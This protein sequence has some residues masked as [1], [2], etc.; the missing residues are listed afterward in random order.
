MRCAEEDSGECLPTDILSMLTRCHRFYPLLPPA[1]DSFEL[2][3]LAFAMSD[4]DFLI[5]VAIFRPHLDN[6]IRG[7]LLTGWARDNQNV[8]YAP[9]YVE[10]PTRLAPLQ[11]GAPR[12]T[13]IGEEFSHVYS[14]LKF[15][16]N[17]IGASLVDQL[18][19][20]PFFSRRLELPVVPCS[21]DFRRAALRQ[22]VAERQEAFADLERALALRQHVREVTDYCDR[23]ERT[24]ARLLDHFADLYLGEKIRAQEIKA[25]LA[26]GKRFSPNDFLMKT[27]NR[28]LL[29][30][31]WV[32]VLN[33]FDSKLLPTDRKVK[34]LTDAFQ[35]HVRKV[36]RPRIEAWVQLNP[37][38][39]V[40]LRKVAQRLLPCQR[41]RLGARLRAFVE[42]IGALGILESEL[43]KRQDVTWQSMFEC[44]MIELDPLILFDSF[45]VWNMS[46]FSDES[47]RQFIGDVRQGALDQLMTGFVTMAV[48]TPALQKD[49]QAYLLAPKKAGGR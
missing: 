37:H 46:V 27:V 35:T 47:S 7:E 19:G 8:S 17:A 23:I 44:V 42:V 3:R 43:V 5:L 1:P 21:D 10:V 11:S 18:P 39:S 33:L 26:A 25:V 31:W 45:R 12:A 9:F 30:H 14:Q 36:V 2:P 28:K 13:A 29:F 15:S 4:R 34:K 32:A 20:T 41:M 22:F 48:G 49:L 6:E 38:A 24:R 16:T 40:P